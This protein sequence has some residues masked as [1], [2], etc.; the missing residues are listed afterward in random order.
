M[1]GKKQ[2]PALEIMQ[3]FFKSTTELGRELQLYRAFFDV[4]RLSEVKAIEFV[5]IISAQKKKLNERLLN[6]QKY[7]LIKEIKASYD[8]ESFL[9]TKVPSYKIYASIYKTFMVESQD[10]TDMSFL[11]IQDIVTSKFALI[12]HLIK[13]KKPFKKPINNSLLE[14]QETDIEKDLTFKFL[15]ERFNDKYDNLGERQK[16]FLKK[17]ISANPGNPEFV[18]YVK[19][20]ITHIQE[21]LNA[22]CKKGDNKVLRIKLQEI[23]NQL[24]SISG[25][26]KFNNSELT[27]VIIGH[28]I[29]QELST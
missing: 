17:Y 12:E 28:Q 29:L 10:S 11:N 9:K 6:K 8:L 21:Q 25:K 15:V 5:D 27:A 24:T 23:N 7:E 22:Y 16:Q 1:A 18:N 19:N 20:E 13:E 4:N 3:E 2:S 26:D 14:S